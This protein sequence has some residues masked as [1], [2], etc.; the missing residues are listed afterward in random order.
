MK[1]VL[2]RTSIA[3]FLLFGLYAVTPAQSQIRFA[4]GAHSATV[5]G[6]IAKDGT[7]TYTFSA[8]AGQYLSLSI[9]SGNN[10]VFAG[11]EAIGQGRSVSGRLPYTGSYVL[12][13]ENGGNA[14]NYTMTISIR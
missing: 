9:R 12:S 4:R 1:T 2:L 14:T 11:V 5:S 10:Y 13:L 8:R 7:R 6:R 3:L